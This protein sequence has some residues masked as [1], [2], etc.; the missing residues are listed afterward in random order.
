MLIL[1]VKTDEWVKITTPEGRVIRVGIVLSMGRE[2]MAFEA[3]KDVKIAR[4]SILPREERRQP[5]SPA[6]T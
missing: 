6:R 3:D 2:R 5:K 1:Q 4:E